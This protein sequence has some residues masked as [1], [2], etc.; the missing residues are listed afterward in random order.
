MPDVVIGQPQFAPRDGNPSRSAADCHDDAV[1]RP[2]S[3]AGSYRPAIDEADI[4][5]LGVKVD[6]LIAQMAGHVFLVVDVL[7]DPFAVG[8]YR[9]NVGTGEAPNSPNRSQELQ[10][11]MSRV[12]R[13]RV[14]TG[15]G[16]RLTLVPRRPAP[17]RAG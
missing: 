5:L 1:S 9:S 2:R 10:S 11:R 8:Q 15:A 6:P 17:P 12:A 14:R 3:I 16:P 4:A 13:A 7:G